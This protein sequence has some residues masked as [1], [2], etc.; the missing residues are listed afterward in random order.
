MDSRD[1]KTNTDEHTIARKMSRRLIPWECTSILSNFKKIRLTSY[2]RWNM[3]RNVEKM[4]LLYNELRNVKII[5]LRLILYERMDNEKS[6]M[7]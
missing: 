6:Y 1:E 7:Y 4:R 5:R 2:E 3:Q